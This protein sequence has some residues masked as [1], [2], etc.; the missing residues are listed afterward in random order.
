MGMLNF[1]KKQKNFLECWNDFQHLFQECNIMLFLDF[2]GTLATIVDQPKEALLLPEIKALLHIL[3][4]GSS[5]ALTIVTGRSLEDIQHKIGIKKIAYIANHGF[6]IEGINVHFRNPLFPKTAQIYREIEKELRE[7]FKEIPE[8]I[9]ED[10]G[11][12]LSIH[13]RIVPKKKKSFV[14]RTVQRV[15]KPYIR[16]R[17]IRLREGKE[18]L[19]VRPA[20]GWDKGT[21]VRWLLNAS[22]EL[23]SQKSMTIYIGDDDTDEDA[24]KALQGQAMTIRVGESKASAAQYYLNDVKQVHD[25]LSRIA[26]LKR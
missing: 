12:T 18:V 25:F 4:R 22:K 10:K 23:T 5:V 9:F 3:S 24:F 16:L 13:F 1:R 11:S 14:K 15:A 21:A 7:A 19:E 17:E 6:E 2:D 8:I 26:E 20:M